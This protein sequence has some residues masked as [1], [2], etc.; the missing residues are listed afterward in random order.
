MMKKLYT[1][2]LLVIILPVIAPAEDSDGIRRIDQNNVFFASQ[3]VFAQAGDLNDNPGVLNEFEDNEGEKSVGRA[4][5]YSLLLPGLGEWYCERKGRAVFFFAA[6]AGIWSAYAL[7]KHKQGWLEDDYINYAVQYAGIDPDG[8]DDFFYDMLAFYENRDEYNKVS[9]VYTR[10][11]PFFPEIPSWDWQWHSDDHRLRYRD[12]KNDSRAN[13]RNANFVLGAAFANRIISAIDAWRSAR[14][15][16]RQFSPLANFHL[17]L[18]PSLAEVI[19]GG[20]SLGIMVNYE[21]KF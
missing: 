11:H 15:Y 16:N 5:L 9:R 18:T 4:I 1:I 13:G 19:T 7:F 17:R 21:Y 3:D 8:K 6:E 2:L 10:T 20:G 12:I 14:A